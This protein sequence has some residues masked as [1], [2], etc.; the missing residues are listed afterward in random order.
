MKKADQI[1][2]IPENKDYERIY[3]NPN[4]ENIRIIGVLS[5]LIKK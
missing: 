3:L 4:D 2:L 1:I 5:G